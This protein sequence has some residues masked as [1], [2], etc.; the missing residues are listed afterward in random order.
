MSQQ[1]LR[2]GS[3]DPYWEDE[4][5]VFAPRRAVRHTAFPVG[6]A[7]EA[8]GHI[9]PA[10]PHTAF[11][12]V[13]APIVLDRIT[14]VP[15][16]DLVGDDSEIV[17]EDERAGSP[18]AR[19]LLDAVSELRGGLAISQSDL[20][21]VLGLSPSTVMAWRRTPA[22]HP[23]HPSVPKLLKLWAAFHACSSVLGH[24]AAAQTAWSALRVGDAA[25]SEIAVERLLEAAEAAGEDF[26]DDLG[27]AAGAEMS[28]DDL[29]AA[30][31][32]F[33]SALTQLTDGSERPRPE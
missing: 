19:L 20:C 24:E 9:V 15:V 14:L 30:E 32:A 8:I 6:S 27:P 5:V 33:S 28:E 1:T 10:L 29:T 25:S 17:T 13:H 18:S 3:A 22:V 2:Q 4:D 26:D 23:R 7:P 21:S 11:E 31:A 16:V 12:R